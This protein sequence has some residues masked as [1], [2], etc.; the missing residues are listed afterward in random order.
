MDSEERDAPGGLT[1]EEVLLL[2]EARR[3]GFRALMLVLDRLRPGSVS[4]LGGSASA[5]E[6]QVR[7]RQDP[8]LAFS[9]ADV[10]DVR[11]VTIPAEAGAS[12]LPR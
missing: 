6:E 1:P 12:G 10:V 11:P 2:E 9:V 4:A 3:A 7:F 8:S 5:H